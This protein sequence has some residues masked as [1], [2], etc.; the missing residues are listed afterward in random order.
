MNNNSNA[1]TIVTTAKAMSSNHTNKPRRRF[2]ER[3]LSESYTQRS[4]A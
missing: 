1:T 3:P 4:I 2:S